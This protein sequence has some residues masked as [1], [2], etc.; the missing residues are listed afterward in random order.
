MV[1]W[2]SEYEGAQKLTIIFYAEMAYRNLDGGERGVGGT[3]CELPESMGAHILFSG[4]L[5]LGVGRRAGE[6]RY[7]HSFDSNF[8]TLP[9]FLCLLFF[10][11]DT[12]LT[13][14]LF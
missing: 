6:R 14:R 9:F 1:A 11:F 2:R 4:F 5:D 12:R 3:V 10:C 8:C 13:G 7:G